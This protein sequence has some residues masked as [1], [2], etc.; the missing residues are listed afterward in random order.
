MSQQN[1]EIVRR[2]L[3]TM[4]G[5]DYD[6]AVR[7]FHADAKWHNT[8]E[9]PGPTICSGPAEIKA[10][11]KALFEDFEDGQLEIEETAETGD[12]VV[13]GLHSQA[14]GKASG[15]PLDVRWAMS[16]RFEGGKIIRVDV[17]GDYGRALQ[18]VGLSE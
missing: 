2:F 5:G 11:W 9:F 10:F 13:V 18:A 7:E 4:V 12:T 17:Y 15:A 3:V 8:G 16:S 6:I 14:R 1:L